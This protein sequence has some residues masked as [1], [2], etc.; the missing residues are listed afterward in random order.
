MHTML[1]PAGFTDATMTV[2]ELR[3]AM[4]E[5]RTRVM[6]KARRQRIAA[7]EAFLRAN[8]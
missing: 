4:R 1:I 2:R 8:A 7:K 5:S 6:R 3:L